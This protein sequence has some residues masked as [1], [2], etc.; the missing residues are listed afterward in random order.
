MVVALKKAGRWTIYELDPDNL[1]KVILGSE[2][3]NDLIQTGIS[4]E[5]A[6]QKL[7]HTVTAASDATIPWQCFQKED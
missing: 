7:I 3:D 6:V 2:C 5:V 4:V 1:E